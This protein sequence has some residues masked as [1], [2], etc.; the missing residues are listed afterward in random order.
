[1]ARADLM[2]GSGIA[3]VL[4]QTTATQLRKD[5]ARIHILL[6]KK[7]V[8]HCGCEETPSNVYGGDTSA[9]PAQEHGPMLPKTASDYFMKT[10][11]SRVLRTTCS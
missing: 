9:P 8:I 2:C 5:R 6:Q 11:I 3:L 4:D 10:R 7:I 1:V